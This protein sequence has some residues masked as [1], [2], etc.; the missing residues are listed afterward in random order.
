MSKECE[1][2]LQALARPER[3]RRWQVEYAEFTAAY[4]EDIE[5][6]G[7]PLDSWRTF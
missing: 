5:A 4:N 7:V 6:A 3:N 1:I 2:F